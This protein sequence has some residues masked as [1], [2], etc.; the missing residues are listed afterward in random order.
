MTGS[1]ICLAPRATSSPTFATVAA[2]AAAADYDRDGDLDL[3]IG[4]RS[5]PGAFP[6]SPD[7]RLLNNKDGVTTNSSTPLNRRPR[8]TQHTGW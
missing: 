1:G 2:I 6:K 8:A 3:F 7:S 4:S 5:I